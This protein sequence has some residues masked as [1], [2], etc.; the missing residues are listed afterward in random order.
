MKAWYHITPHH[1]HITNP[2][3]NKLTRNMVSCGD[4]FWKTTLWIEDLPDLSSEADSAIAGM[5]NKR[6]RQSQRGVQYGARDNHGGSKQAG[7]VEKGKIDSLFTGSATI[8]VHFGANA[9]KD[10]HPAG[11]H[12]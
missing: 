4:I 8:F 3:A 12:Q 2:H 10:C 9:R 6:V 7:Q 5:G 1:H 11:L